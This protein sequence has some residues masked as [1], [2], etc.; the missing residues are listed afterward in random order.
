MAIAAI[1]EA[2]ASAV[3]ILLIVGL[4][5]LACIVELFIVTFRS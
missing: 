4:E 3:T 5:F 1:T 2:T